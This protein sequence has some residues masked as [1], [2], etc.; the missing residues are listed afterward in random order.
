MGKRRPIL[1]TTL[2]PFEDIVLYTKGSKGK[3]K[4]LFCPECFLEN[5]LNQLSG[6]ANKKILKNM[7]SMVGALNAVV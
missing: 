5:T 7:Y 4:N 6:T 1:F 2:L 3:V